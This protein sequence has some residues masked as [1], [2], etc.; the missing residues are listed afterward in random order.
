MSEDVGVAKN[1]RLLGA[2]S[3]V[4]WISTIYWK[5]ICKLEKPHTGTLVK[6]IGRVK[7]TT[8]SQMSAV[9]HLLAHFGTKAITVSLYSTFLP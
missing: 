6:I 8:T 9:K 3:F 1:C 4:P 2:F 7:S 5:E